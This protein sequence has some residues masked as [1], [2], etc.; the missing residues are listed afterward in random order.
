M[1]AIYKCTKLS[2]TGRS[3]LVSNAYDIKVDYVDPTVVPPLDGVVICQIDVDR[4]GDPTTLEADID[5]T[6]TGLSL[7]TIDWTL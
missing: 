5:T 2:N 7:D 6:F 3:I 1:A 4:A